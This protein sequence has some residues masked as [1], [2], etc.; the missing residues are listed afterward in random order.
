MSAYINTCD[1]SDLSK[2]NVQSFSWGNMYVRF[3]GRSS[4]V[5]IFEGNMIVLP[6]ETP[7]INL[8]NASGL[9]FS[10]SAVYVVSVHFPF[11]PTLV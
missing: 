6:P 1:L 11:K 9:S 10:E 3:L 8:D 7:S 5:S 2:L 4:N